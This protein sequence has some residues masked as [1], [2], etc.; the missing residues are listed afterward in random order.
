MVFKSLNIDFESS[1]VSASFSLYCE[2]CLN[3][4]SG[5]TSTYLGFYAD[6]GRGYVSD[7]IYSGLDSGFVP[8]TD[9]VVDFGIY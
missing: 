9:S 5:F 7:F 1:F 3:C 2:P 8:D 4:D 6:Y